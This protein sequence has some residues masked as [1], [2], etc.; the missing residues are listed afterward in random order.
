MVSE[1]AR[2]RTATPSPPL[3]QLVEPLLEVLHAAST[4]PPDLAAQASMSRARFVFSQFTSVFVALVT[5]FSLVIL[6]LTKV[7][8]L[9]EAVLC[10]LLPHLANVSLPE[11]LDENICPAKK[12]AA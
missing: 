2:R 12:P 8:D 7:G 1:G 9:R 10:N 5:L 3:V 6:A 11:G 4:S